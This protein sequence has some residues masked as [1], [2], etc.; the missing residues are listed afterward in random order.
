MP[1]LSPFP[2]S[3]RITPSGNLQQTAIS[4]VDNID[5]HTPPGAW[6]RI[7]AGQETADSI[8]R[9]AA[10]GLAGIVLGNAREGADLQRVDVLLSAAEAL[11]G[12]PVGGMGIVARAADHPAGVLA[13]SSFADKS[14]RLVALGG[15]GD[16]LRHALGLAS[17]EAEPLRQ[18]RG[19]LVL[20]AAAAG[21]PALAG[22]E[23]GLAPEDFEA[24]CRRDRD[25]G[26][27]GKFVTSDEEARIVNAVF[28]S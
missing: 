4:V 15:G 24:L 7:E 21:V 14:P 12:R 22:A 28:G 9:A 3:W 25:Q 10:S 18:A 6:M 16:T 1:L 27:H 26:F 11:S 2:R 17:R 23:A 20:A 13:L 8:R 19:L 5:A